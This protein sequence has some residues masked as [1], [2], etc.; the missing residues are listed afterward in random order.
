MKISRWFSLNRFTS[1]RVAAAATLLAAGCAIA[2]V[3]TRT[4]KN[5]KAMTAVRSGGNPHKAYKNLFAATKPG[6]MERGPAALA[7]EKNALRAYPADY[8]PFELTQK[9]NESWNAFQSQS[10]RA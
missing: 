4:D 5:D 1:L 7:E 6:S 2:I 9:A 10:N 8:V 3:G